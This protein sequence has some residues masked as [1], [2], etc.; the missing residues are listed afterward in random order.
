MAS[1]IKEL[2]YLKCIFIVL[3]IIFHLVYIADK[4]PYAKNVVYA[5][6]M[7]AFLILS[8]YLANIDK[9]LKSFLKGMLWIFIPYAIMETGYTVMSA[10]VPTRNPIDEVTLQLLLNKAFIA[11]MGPYW[12]LHT[13]VVCSIVYYFVY[14]YIRMDSFSRFILLSICFYL[15][16]SVCG[17]MS[18]S[19]AIYFL[20][21]V[22]VSRSRQGFLTVFRSSVLA[23]IP[24]VFFCCFPENLHRETLAGVTITYL[25][26]SFLL[27]IYHY[28]PNRIKQYSYFIGRN[29]LVILLFSPIFTILS[30]FFVPVFA[31]DSSGMCFMCV[32]VTFVLAGCFGITW[33]MDKLHFSTYFFGR[34]QMLVYK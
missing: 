12:Y 25:V 23:I 5:F 15:L 13:L 18:F 33:L 8:G 11:P 31:F 10:V 7:S 34:K 32:A 9:P 24:L 29:T 6:H 26:I 16:S 22:A 1:R 21:G 30:K 27:F 4:Y 3:M 19:N 17:L 14:N 20:I 28:L 2:D